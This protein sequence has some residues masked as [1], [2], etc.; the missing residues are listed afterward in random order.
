MR[1]IVLLA[2]IAF[3]QCGDA[4]EK[5]QELPKPP[6]ALIL[7][8]D[9]S[10]DCDDAGAV[11]VLHAL[12]D[13]GEVQILGMMVSMPVEY[14]A[15]ALDAIN[16]FYNRPNIPIGTLKNSQDGIKSGGLK[17]YNEDLTRRFPN[18]LKHAVYAPNAV[19]LYRRLLA[20][21]NDA[22]VTIVSIGPLTN[23]YHLLQSTSDSISPLTG[24]ELVKKKVRR[25]V[26]AGGRLPEGSSYNFW[27]APEKAEYV[28]THW[29]TEHGFVPNQMGDS[30][31]TGE[32]LLKR[33]SMGNPV[34]M[35]YSLYKAAHPT[36]A[37]RP[38][39]DQMAILVAVR[40]SSG[41]FTKE[42]N[43]RVTVVGDKLKWMKDKDRNHVW[44]R[45]A[46]TPE[47]R[48]MLIEDLMTQEP[49]KR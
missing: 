29:P 1:I 32:A 8:T 10:A 28:V 40:P 38:S 24:V 34:R 49:S 45:T 14:G 22:S 17:T 7:D 2:V 25:L 44:F 27:T 26:T 36:W 47:S 16:T 37:F 4:I 30:V 20:N 3:V 19:S 39:W 35:A 21:E 9:I 46:T 15:P 6:I 23:L 48:R 11:A 43:G 33:T 42:T 18:D 5:E 41:M 13:K 31:L 12:A